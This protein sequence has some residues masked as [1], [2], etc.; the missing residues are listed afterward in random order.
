MKIR[1]AFLTRSLK[2]GTKLEFKLV[3]PPSKHIGFINFVNAAMKGKSFVRISLEQ[4]G[5]GK[6][7][8]FPAIGEFQFQRGESSPSK[9]Q[10]KRESLQGIVFE[11]K[12]KYQL[13]L[14]TKSPVKGEDIAFKLRIPPRKQDAMQ[15]F[16]NASIK[17]N[18]TIVM[19]FKKISGDKRE[20]SKIQGEFQF[21]N[22]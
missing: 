22:E 19:Y 18:S 2:K 7:K 16:L 8:T 11:E 1:L 12:G 17:G 15:F 6:G 3:V 21:F 4:R 5:Q 9:V 20:R 14:S 10:V 13:V